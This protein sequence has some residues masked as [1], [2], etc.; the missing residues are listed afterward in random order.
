[1]NSLKGR[2]LRLTAVALAFVVSQLYVVRADLMRSASLAPAAAAKRAVQAPQARLTTQGD[3]S[4]TVGGN[5]AKTGETIFS[6]QQ[7]QTPAG[8]GATVDVAGVGRVDIA[9]GSNVKIT[10]EEGRIGVVV[11]SGCATLTA[12]R[13]EAGTL[14]ADGKTQTTDTANG[15]T[16]SNCTNAVPGAAVPAGAAA[17]AGAG[18]SSGAA[19]A[20][21]A[22]AVTAFSLLARNVISDSTNPGPTTCTPLPVNPSSGLPPGCVP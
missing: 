1:M 8:T 2:N 11:T 20:L 16:V 15:G 6:G 13:G 9:P 10:F 18:L 3:K 14:E 21:T 12:N 5:S 7:I 22:A 17:G 4:I 19:V